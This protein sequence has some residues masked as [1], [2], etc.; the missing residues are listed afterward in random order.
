MRRRPLGITVLGGFY[1]VF[2][3][4][5][6]AATIV[7]GRPAFTA[8]A[9]ALG[10]VGIGL[11]LMAR[12]TWAAALLLQGVGVLASLAG[13]AVGLGGIAIGADAGPFAPLL[14]GAALTTSLP[15]AVLLSLSTLYL[16]RVRRAFFAPPTE[17]PTPPQ[18]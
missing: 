15:S 2:L 13:V 14:G 3:V 16:L 7:N 17:P 10:L 1:V 6:I 9:L 12:W 4:S 11:W 8:G 5:G 18:S